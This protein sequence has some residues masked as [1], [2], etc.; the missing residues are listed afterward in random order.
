MNSQRFAPHADAVELHGYISRLYLVQKYSSS[1]L[2]EVSEQ[3]CTVT[4][5]AVR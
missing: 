4:E 3:P 5:Q 2:T 1:A